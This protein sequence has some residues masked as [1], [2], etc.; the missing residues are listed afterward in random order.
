MAIGKQD[1]ILMITAQGK[2]I[3]FPVVGVSRMGRA[4]QGV[5]LLQ[6]DP[7]DVVASAIRT[8]EEAPQTEE[9]TA[10]PGEE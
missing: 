3:R 5:K 7:G 2:L 9:E 6:V 8:E 4:T 1:E 10:E